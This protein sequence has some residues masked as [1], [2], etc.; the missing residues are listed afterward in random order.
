MQASSIT[1]SQTLSQSSQS[2]AHSASQIQVD[3]H[4]ASNN[5]GNEALCFEILGTFVI[6]NSGSY[7]T[8]FA[9]KQILVLTLPTT[10]ECGSSLI[11][12]NPQKYGILSFL[13]QSF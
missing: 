9:N 5:R 8:L 3:V 6:E 12:E 7:G 4:N 13:E 10:D 11:L 2:S 1:S